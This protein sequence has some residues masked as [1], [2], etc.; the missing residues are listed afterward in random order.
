MEFLS[1]HGGYTKVLIS[2]NF[3]IGTTVVFDER[4]FQWSSF[5]KSLPSGDTEN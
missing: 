3:T 5:W 2:L 4:E 1:F